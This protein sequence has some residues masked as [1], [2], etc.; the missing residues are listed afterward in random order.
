MENNKITYV[1]GDAT[2]P[3]KNTPIRI[4]PHV[5]NDIGAWGTGFVLALSRMWPGPEASYKEWARAGIDMIAG[6]FKL[7]NVQLV[8]VEPN[9]FIANIIG[10]R[11]T[12]YS[13]GMPPVRYDAIRSG[14]K[15]IRD[16]FRGS[17]FSIHAPKFG[18][19]LA[20]GDWNI[21]ESIIEE[22]LCEKGVPVTVYNFGG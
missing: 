20:G 18:S 12:G 4:I 1:T 14:L 11:V 10:Q 5:C 8:E 2:K 9:L 15:H 7:G 19:A 16:T 17:D 6:A 22:E 13:D 21:I 3:L